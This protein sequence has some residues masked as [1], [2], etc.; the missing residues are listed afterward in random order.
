MDPLNSLAY[1]KLQRD[2]ELQSA[3]IRSARGEYSH[4]EPL[5]E[6]PDGRD[7]RGAARRRGLHGDRGGEDA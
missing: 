6:P 3:W 7:G 4:D 5:A 1:V 2:V